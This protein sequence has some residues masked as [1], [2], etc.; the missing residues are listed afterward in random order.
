MPKKKHLEQL[1]SQKLNTI[2]SIAFFI[3][4]EAALLA[5][6]TSSFL[7]QYIDIRYLGYI[8]VFGN[9]ISAILIFK[10][11]TWVAKF[12]RYKLFFVFFLIHLLSLVGLATVKQK[13]LAIL[14]F[15]FYI[16]TLFIIYIGIDIFTET[17]SCDESTGSIK[18]KQLTVRNLAWVA[19]PIIAGYLLAAYGFNL[20]FLIAGILVFISFAVFLRL[21]G[22]YDHDHSKIKF[23]ESF[24]KIKRDKNLS[25]IIL[26]SLWLEIFFAFMI[27][28]M[29]LYLRQIGMDWTQIGLVFTI[30]LSAFVIFQYPAGWLA[31]NKCGEKEILMLGFLL[32]GITTCLI[33][34]IN[35]AVVWIWAVALFANRIGI[36]LIQVMDESYFY[37]QIDARDIDLINFFRLMR[38]IGYIITPLIASIVLA[39]Y[40]LQYLFLFLGIFMLAGL[41]V[42][43]RIEDTR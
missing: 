21:K 22:D 27:I 31:D 17:F 2:I 42:V 5:Y 1:N 13:A 32:A 29:P 41:F 43:G 9:I 23:L 12:G 3:A 7:E 15:L 10:L 35:S 11:S 26:G 16:V 34:F 28:Y 6:I 20:L 8:F 37:K 25:Q 38:P 18:G 24:R 40:P 4:L 14:F 36:S 30:M 19:A 33:F 39:F